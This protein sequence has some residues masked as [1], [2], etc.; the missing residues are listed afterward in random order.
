MRPEFKHHTLDDCRV[1]TLARHHEFGCG[2]MS[3]VEN[4][5]LYPFAVKRIFYIYDVPA[6]ACRGGHS[7]YAEQCLLVAVQGAFSVT[8]D[9]GIERRVI[10]LDK[11]WHALYIPEGIWR[12]MSDFSAGCVALAL[13]S[14]LYDE[15]DY[16]RS[17]ED[18][19]ALS[20]TE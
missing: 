15:A 20:A 9:N 5:S 10:R 18:F 13:S 7:H 19:K 14:S 11:P 12:E 16:I 3:A 4:S 1:V 6:G 17:Y 2:D 8:V